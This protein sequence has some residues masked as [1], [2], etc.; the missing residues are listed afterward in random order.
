MGRTNADESLVFGRL[1]WTPASVLANLCPRA[2]AEPV[3][4]EVKKVTVPEVSGGKSDAPI[5]A[6]LLPPELGNLE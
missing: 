6:L 5:P 1:F 2:W 4:V 3:S